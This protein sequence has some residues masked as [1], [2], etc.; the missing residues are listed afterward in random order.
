M[1]AIFTPVTTE[2]KYVEMHHEVLSEALHGV[3]VGF[4][5]NNVSIKDIPCGDT[6]VTAKM[7]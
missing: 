4:D 6:V 3:S 1:V 2:A 5:I 7:I